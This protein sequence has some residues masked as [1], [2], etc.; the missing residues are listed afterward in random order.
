MGGR[1]V[2][3]WTCLLLAVSFPCSVFAFTE[4]PPKSKPEDPVGLDLRKAKAE[5]TGSMEKA[6]AKLAADFSEIRKRVEDSTTLKVEQ[7]LKLLEQIQQEKAAFDA[8]PSKMPTL[9]SMK[10]AVAEYQARTAAARK[11]CEAA[12]DKAAESY[13]KNKDFAA[14]K[15]ILDEK[16]DFAAGKMVVEEKKTP[17]PQPSVRT[18]AGLYQ[19]RFDREVRLAPDGTA[20]RTA[21]NAV[22]A[23]G[24]WKVRNEQCVVTWDSGWTDVLAFDKDGK[25]LVGKQISPKKKDGEMIYK[26]IGTKK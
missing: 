15:K 11:K 14:A 22:V 16:K 24:N 25:N 2:R 7:R 1:S 18:F 9:V 21:K 4:E 26:I 20:T 10:A 5:C 12:Y 17:S 19:D 3:T 6:A 8:S 23:N 13:D